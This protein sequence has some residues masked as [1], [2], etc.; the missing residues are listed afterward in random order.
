MLIA[1]ETR[2]AGVSPTGVGIFPHRR[3]RM[4]RNR[5]LNRFPGRS[6]HG[7][8]M[9][10]PGHGRGSDTRSDEVSRRGSGRATTEVR[11]FATTGGSLGLLTDWLTFAGYGRRIVP[12]PIQQQL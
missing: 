5:R 6:G 11:T 3:R 9:R 12:G 1:L 7:Q 4:A 8:R 2:D 10:S